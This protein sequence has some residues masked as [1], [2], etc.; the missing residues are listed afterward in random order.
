M[1]EIIDSS[2]GQSPEAKV[3]IGNNTK[4]Q[5]LEYKVKDNV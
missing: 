3:Y 1:A 4:E 5:F 2:N